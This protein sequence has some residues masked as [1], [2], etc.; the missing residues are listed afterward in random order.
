M[1][2]RVPGQAVPASRAVPDAGSQELEDRSPSPPRA[3]GLVEES[4]M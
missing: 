3:H 2:P 4:D 1:P